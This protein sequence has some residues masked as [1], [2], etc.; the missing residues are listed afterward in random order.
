MNSTVCTKQEIRAVIAGS[1]VP[2]DSRHAENTLEWLLRLK[3]DADETMHL[4]A[5]GHDIERA[6]EARKVKRADFIDYDT[7]KAAHARNSAEILRAI[8][9][10]CGVPQEMAGE[11]YLL[12][13]RHET[14]G[15]PRADLIKNADCI[16]YFH[17]NMPLYYQREG[18][19][20]TKR[21]CVWGYRR[22]S[23]GVKKI[24]ENMVYSDEK[25]TKLLREAI[26]EA[27][28]KD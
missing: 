13:Y 26:R 27:H 5:L 2:E 4:A 11:V 25:L 3:P 17:V 12:V 10:D 20:E 8:M 23:A 9:E 28:S 1:R 24:V 6:L 18:W 14:G 21:R 19:E 22:L 7:F 15:D 16:S